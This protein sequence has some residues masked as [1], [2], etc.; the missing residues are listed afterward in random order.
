MNTSVAWEQQVALFEH[1]YILDLP[2]VCL[3]C[4]TVAPEFQEK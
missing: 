4:Q 2:A 1:S 3:T